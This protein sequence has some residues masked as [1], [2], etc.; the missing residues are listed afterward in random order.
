M[1]GCPVCGRPKCRQHPR[2]RAAPERRPYSGTALE[3]RVKAEALELYGADCAI[4]GGAID[5]EARSGDGKLVMAHVIA[6]ADGG[7]FTVENVRP[8]HALCNLRQGRKPLI[9]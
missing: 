4:C 3:R 8:A 6:H 9:G 5:L 1:R 7:E 2:R